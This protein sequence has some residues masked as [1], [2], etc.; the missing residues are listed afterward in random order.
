MNEIKFEQDVNEWE[1]AAFICKNGGMFNEYDTHFS[2]WLGDN[3]GYKRFKDGDV[4]SFIDGK[5]KIN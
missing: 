3:M 5:F 4:I 2:I 1:V